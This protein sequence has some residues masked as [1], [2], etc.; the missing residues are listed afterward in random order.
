[1]KPA[2]RSSRTGV[3]RAGTV[4]TV[5]VL[6]DMAIG[7]ARWFAFVE[8]STEDEEQKAIAD[9]NQYQLGGRGLCVN[10]GRPKPAY[11]GRSAT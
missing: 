9:L 10:E 2:R 6:R 3:A 5:K 11:V 7:W 4:E 8:M 1:M